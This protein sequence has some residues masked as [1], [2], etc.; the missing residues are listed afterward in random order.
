MLLDHLRRTEQLAFVEAIFRDIQRKHFLDDLSGTVGQSI[1]PSEPIKGV[2]VLIS[3]MI[4]SRPDLESQVV[5]WLS[6][7]QGGSINTLGLRRALLATLSNRGSK[8]ALPKGIQ[9][10]KLRTSIGVLKSLLIRSLDQFGDK[11]S[12][13]HVP[14]VV[15]NGLSTVQCPLSQ[16]IV[17]DIE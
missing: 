10:M 3:V 2:A 15:Q 1:T 14:N 8:F 17:S 16:N 7:S 9:T 5:E 4:S 12:I 13:K 11:F 6:K